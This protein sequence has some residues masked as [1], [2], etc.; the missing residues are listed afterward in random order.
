MFDFFCFLFDIMVCWVV[1]YCFGWLVDF[2]FCVWVYVGFVW[3]G[4]LCC[5]L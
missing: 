5:I 1:R 4:S 3:I 2:G